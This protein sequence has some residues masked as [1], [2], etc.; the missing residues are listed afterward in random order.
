[1]VLFFPVREE[2][3]DTISELIFAAEEVGR[4]NLDF[5]IKNKSL[6]KNKVNNIEKISPDLLIKGSDYLEEESTF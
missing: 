4:G 5:Q 6:L 1:M 3:K 2:T